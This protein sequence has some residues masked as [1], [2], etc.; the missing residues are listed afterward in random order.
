M[1]SSGLLKTTAEFCVAMNE[2]NSSND[3]KQTLA[4]FPQLQQML[5]FIYDPFMKWGVSPANIKKF[6]TTSGKKQ[7][8]K[9]QRTQD[10]KPTAESDIFV[11]LDKLSSRQLTGHSAILAVLAFIAANRAYE[12]LIYKII[13]KDLKIGVGATIINSVFDKLI[14]EFDVILANDFQKVA[15]KVDFESD[16]WFSSRKLDGCR[17]IVMIDGA[18]EV[19]FFSRQGNEFTSLDSAVADIK[20]LGLRNAVL[21]SETCILNDD[22]SENF[23]AVVGQIKKKNFTIPA[24]RLYLFDMVKLEEF[25]AGHSSDIFSVRQANLANALASYFGQVLIHLEQ[26]KVDNAEHLAAMSDNASNRGYEGLIVRKDVAY[27]AKRSNDTLKV[28]KF[29]EA[30]FSVLDV[31]MSTKQMLKN[32]QKVE[33]KTL[34]SVVIEY[35][36]NKVNVGSGF[37][38]EERERIYKEPDSIIGK[39]IAVQYFEES[40]NKAGGVSMRFPTKKHIYWTPRDL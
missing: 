14:P 4:K 26:I 23:A 16:V 17:T 24:P 34:G 30:E 37:T 22:G 27:E 13:D 31:E 2:S 11:L 25:Q 28:K 33:V 12:E 7:A 15:H 35:K 1:A 18:G 5:R 19:R 29:L 10:E 3:K 8:S 38:D 20:S 6:A 21:D 9:R 36:G 39:Q 32:G 40:S